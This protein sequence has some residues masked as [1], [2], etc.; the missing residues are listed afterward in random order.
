MVLGR[1][2][3][4]KGRINVGVKLAKMTSDRTNISFAGRRNNFSYRKCD[5]RTMRERN[6]AFVSRNAFFNQ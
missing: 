2:R 4:D 3:K 6:N 5:V 1:N